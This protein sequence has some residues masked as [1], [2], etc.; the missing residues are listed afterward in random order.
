M[1]LCLVPVFGAIHNVVKW[2]ATLVT[3]TGDRTC[4]SCDLIDLVLYPHASSPAHCHRKET[5][6]TLCALSLSY[7]YLKNTLLYSR[8]ED[9]SCPC[10]VRPLYILRLTSKLRNPNSRPSLTTPALQLQ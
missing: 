9:V 5:I 10:D 7:A 4:A 3:L 8:A 2:S 6:C 1:R